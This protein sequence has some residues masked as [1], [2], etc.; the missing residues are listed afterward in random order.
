MVMKKIALKDI[1]PYQNNAKIHTKEQIELIAKSIQDHG[2][3]QDIAVDANNVIVIGHGRWEALKK[4]N[5][6]TGE[7]S[8]IE[9]KD[10]SHIPHEKL[11]KLR[12]LDNKLNEMTGFNKSNLEEEIISIYSELDKDIEKITSEL[13]MSERDIRAIFPDEREGEDDVP[14][15]RET[16]IHLGDIYRLG[17]HRL[18]CADCRDENALQLLMEGEKADMAFC[19]PPYGVSQGKKNKQLNKMAG[20]DRKEDDIKDDDLDPDALY[21]QLVVA[22]KNLKNIVLAD[23]SSVFTCAP[24]GGGLGMMMMMM[25]EAGLEA[26]HVLIW[27]KNCPTFSMGRL[28]YDYQ[29][30]PI[31][32]SWNKSH[33]FYGEGR[34]RT[35][36]WEFDK[37]R[38]SK[39]HPTMKPIELVENALLNNS[40]RD[41]IVADIYLGSGTTLIACE[42]TGRNCYGTEISPTYCQVIIDRWEKFT[43]KQ[44]I[45]IN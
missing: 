30:E 21:E 19:D 11:R 23:C 20:G 44:A 22:F 27:K 3:V 29:H 8:E 41:D 7:Y 31:L 2:I 33:K 5:K 15:P 10:L 38:A 45:K 35:S 12:I 1:L 39:E 17:E 9:V 13:A 24:Q 18:M 43:G 25:K 4:I 37:P 32:L 6:E 26:K 40:K 36:V 16:S 28:D 34:F 14:E 42:K